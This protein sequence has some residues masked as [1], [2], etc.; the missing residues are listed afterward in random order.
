MRLL[1]TADWHLRRGLHG[2]SLLEDQAHLLGELMRLAR[3]AR[4]DLVI[5][6]GDVFD[7]AV[8]PAEAGGVLGDTLFPAGVGPRVPAGVVARHHDSPPPPA[9]RAPAVGAKRI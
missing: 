4:P 2:A 6:A 8:P 7:R 1:H 5:V 3:D 9:L